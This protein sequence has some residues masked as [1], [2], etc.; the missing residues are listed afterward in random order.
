MIVYVSETNCVSVYSP[1]G[2]VVVL[3]AT[4]AH[5][6]TSGIPVPIGSATRPETE[7]EYVPV[8]F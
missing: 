1:P 5:T 4:P 8:K 7:P 2:S 3:M 6:L